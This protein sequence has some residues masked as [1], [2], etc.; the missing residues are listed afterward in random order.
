MRPF[1]AAAK[2]SNSKGEGEVVG[3]AGGV[4]DGA[5]VGD[6]QAFYSDT[7]TERYSCH[8]GFVLEL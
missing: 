3:G 8:C 1:G 5:G 7:Q 2:L 4:I 6:V